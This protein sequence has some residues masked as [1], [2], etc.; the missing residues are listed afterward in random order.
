VCGGGGAGG[1]KRVMGEGAL[2]FGGGGRQVRMGRRWGGVRG[3][4]VIK[5]TWLGGDGGDVASH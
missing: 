5:E 4:V 3:Q 2:R 1:D